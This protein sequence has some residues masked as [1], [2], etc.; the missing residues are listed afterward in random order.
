MADLEAL[1][2][3]RE[4]S[5]LTGVT[6]ITLRAWERRYDL[7]EP[8]RTESGHRLYTQEHVDFIK[9]AVELTK[10][11]I[12]ISKVKAVINE[13][14]EAEKN[15]RSHGDIDFALELIQACRNYDYLETHQ[16]VDQ[17]YVDLFE[18]QVKKVI[19][20]VTLMVNKEDTA[21][22]VL[23]RSVI[24]PLLSSRIRQGRRLLDKIGR[25]NV[26]ITSTSG[27]QGVL[28]RIMANTALEKGYNPMLGLT[29]KADELMDT[30]KKLRCEA[31]IIIA[32]GAQEKTFNQW[33]SWSADHSSIET[34]FVTDKDTFESNRMNFKV[35]SLHDIQLS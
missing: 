12:P 22:Q 5:R 28:Q 9:Q 6:P 30:L 3:I 1:Y 10:K 16:L 31:L 8:V 20:D 17:L 18:E 4:I 26:Y 19:V 14:K 23:W 27:E 33:N 29:L 25:Q 24:V 11:G 35:V 13:R 21:V 2:P 34:Y 15:L 32:P 7:I